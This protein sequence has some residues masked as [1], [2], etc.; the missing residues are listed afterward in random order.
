MAENK[1]RPSIDEVAS[2]AKP[3][4]GQ[5]IEDQVSKSQKRIENLRDEVHHWVI[6]TVQVAA[7]A[8][9]LI[10]IVRS[11]HM[12]MPAH[13]QWMNDEAVRRIDHMLASGVVGGLISNYA[14]QISNSSLSFVKS[15]ADTSILK[16]MLTFMR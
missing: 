6:V 9:L 13:W 5:K 10:F 16:S 4:D 3:S 8:F 2:A 1:E 15:K 7:V 14:K 12:I 11:L